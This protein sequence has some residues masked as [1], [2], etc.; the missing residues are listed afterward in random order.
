[1]AQDQFNSS[2]ETPY[3]DIFFL[4]SLQTSSLQLEKQSLADFP[5]VYWGV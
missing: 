2:Q 3:L 4:E 1:M 5:H